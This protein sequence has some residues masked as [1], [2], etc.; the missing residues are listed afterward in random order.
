MLN[1][2][3]CF[4]CGIN[5]CEVLLTNSFIHQLAV[6]WGQKQEQ[7]EGLC[8]NIESRLLLVNA[9]EKDNILIE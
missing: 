8:L 5:G 7:V 9:R 4:L 2:C 6:F 1:I 3:L